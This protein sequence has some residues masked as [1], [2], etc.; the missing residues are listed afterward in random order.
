V[1]PDVPSVVGSIS[2]E[3]YD[4][5]GEAYDPLNGYLYVTDSGSDWVSIFSG[6]R[7]VAQ[8]DVGSTPE[9]ALF[10]PSDGMVWVSNRGSGSLTLINGT[11]LNATRPSGSLD[12]PFAMAYDPTL[13]L[14]Y[15]VNVDAKPGFATLYNA[16]TAAY[17]GDVTTGSYPAGVAYDPQNGFM[18]IANA[19]SAANGGAS[20]TVI[21]DETLITTVSGGMSTPLAVLYDRADHFIY[22]SDQNIVDPAVGWLTVI[23][24]TKEQA[25]V[26]VGG[27]PFGE[28]YDP[29]T[30]LVLTANSG[31]NNVSVVQGERVVGT[32]HAGSSPYDAL[33]DAGS[34]LVFVTNGGSDN[35]SAIST[36]LEESAI[37]ATP[38]GNPV[39]TSDLGASVTFNS[40]VERTG[41][42]QDTAT[43]TVDPSSGLG[44]LAV[45]SQ[46]A[47][48][49]GIALS[50][51]CRPTVA[52]TWTVW[53][54][55]TDAAGKTAWAWLAFQ[56]FAPLVTQAPWAT[57][58]ANQVVVSADLGEFVAFHSRAVGGSGND[59]QFAWSGLPSSGCSGLNTSEATCTLAELGSLNVTS[60][61][62]DSNGATS[63]S[64]VLVF[65]VYA[66]PT[67]ARP[68][69]SRDIADV[70]QWVNFTELPSAGPGIF[71]YT[72]SGLDSATCAGTMTATPSC[73]FPSPGNYSVGVQVEDVNG[74][75]AT[76]PDTIV[77]VYSLPST[78]APTTDVAS[79]DIGQT[80]RFSTTDTGGYGA[81][82]F[83]WTGLPPGVCL[84]P[85]SAT[86]SCTL[87]AAGTFTIQ[88][89]ATDGN[90][91][92]SLWSTSTT[93]VVYTDPSVATPTVSPAHLTL[94]GSVRLS[95]STRGGAPGTTYD[96]SGL[97]PGCAGTTAVLACTPTSAGVYWVSVNATDGNGEVADSGM[98]EVNITAPVPVSSNA[99]SGSETYALV[100]LGVVAVVAVAL[101][102][103][104][105]MGRRTAP[106]PR[107]K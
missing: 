79:A 39:D 24:G 63:V 103:G 52:G 73:T 94:G 69:A 40:T 28:T 62:T 8:V 29:L 75:F 104:W 81:I 71:A 60:S 98:A 12:G 50:F 55:V 6:N 17:V 51:E 56:V 76:S 86:P 32:L 64:P 25:T 93:F 87:Q 95:T 26:G 72:W 31:T 22:V 74:Y 16:T 2:S 65:P 77:S 21:L 9:A 54:N 80:V 20:V 44:C 49:E 88:V 68:T 58:A 90:G 48:L 92:T 78:S 7:S 37:S 61:T 42:G 4:P 67:A 13:N 41:A 100:G 84:G 102:G 36:G 99:A 14:V 23:N 34:G 18:Y 46:G 33:Y 43:L 47:S 97:P 107:T 3:G 35:L 57:T 66:H 1:V 19:A 27:G 59:T 5:Y 83:N 10:D 91:A 89:A 96:W 101:Y 45:Q 11:H 53:V 105:R 70:G 30:G 15:V 106:P 85:G 38:S 82:T